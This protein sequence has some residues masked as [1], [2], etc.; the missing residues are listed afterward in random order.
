MT[1]RDLR[2]NAGLTQR[3]VA[4]KLGCWPVSVARI[5]WGEI[6][7]SVDKAAA[8]ANIYSVSVGEVVAAALHSLTQAAK[9]GRRGPGRPKG[10]PGVEPAAV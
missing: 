7:L 9:D 3:Q 1:L 8:L 5:E 4:Q 10:S 6:R 2:E